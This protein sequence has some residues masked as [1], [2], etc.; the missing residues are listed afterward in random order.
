MEYRKFIDLDQ[1]QIF[2]PMVTLLM[3]ARDMY[4]A[5]MVGLLRAASR[6]SSLI[7]PYVF[8]DILTFGSEIFGNVHICGWKNQSKPF[9]ALRLPG[10][11]D[12]G[13]D[14]LVDQLRVGGRL[15]E[16]IRYNLVF[17]NFMYFNASEYI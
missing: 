14:H 15:C 2:L 17:R 6:P 13:V 9:S 7:L 5:S 12:L 8:N 3:M 1:H 4:N 11:V 10:C 16:I